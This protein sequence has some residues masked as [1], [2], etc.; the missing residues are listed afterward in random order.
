VDGLQ[1]R[2][3]DETRDCLGA[4]GSELLGLEYHR[5]LDFAGER[6]HRPA[7]IT[8]M[9]TQVGGAFMAIV[10]FSYYV[11]ANRRKN[12]KEESLRLEI[13]ADNAE[14]HR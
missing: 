8:A 6:R 12:L 4:R 7:K 14:L 3:P 11:W 9:A 10:L 1:L 13:L 2:G 5:P